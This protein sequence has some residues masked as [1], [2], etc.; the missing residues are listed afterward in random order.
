MQ[1]NATSDFVAITSARAPPRPVSI[2]GPSKTRD[3]PPRS[4]QFHAR[5]K[6]LE[7][8]VRHLTRRDLSSRIAHSETVF[9]ETDNT[10]DKKRV[11]K[12]PP[13]DTDTA[14]RVNTHPQ[15]ARAFPRCRVR[16]RHVTVRA[17]PARVPF[18]GASTNSV[19]I[20]LIAFFGPARFVCRRRNDCSENR[21]FVSAK[22]TV[23]FVFHVTDL[24]S[25][26][27][28]AP[29]RVT[30]PPPPPP[31]VPTRPGRC[32]GGQPRRRRW[33]EWRE[34]GAVQRSAARFRVATTHIGC[35]G[36]PRRSGARVDRVRPFVRARGLDSRLGGCAQHQ[37]CPDPRDARNERVV[38]ANRVLRGGG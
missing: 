1:R 11:V 27:L 12:K 20:R 16:T 15:H 30:Q 23:S 29:L 21:R 28:P 22:C 37:L 38:G 17:F 9:S 19:T 36:E 24:P 2:L 32:P 7:R 5:S 26:R 25:P 8:P 34:G 4:V 6:R 14:S 13:N 10:R 33:P 31:Q 3:S 18:P 35:V